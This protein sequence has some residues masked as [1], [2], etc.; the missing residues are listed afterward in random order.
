VTSLQDDITR[1]VK[2]AL[3]AAL[4]AVLL[5]LVIASVNVTNLLL[6]RA[7]QRRGELAMRVALGAGKGRVVRQLLTESLLL[8]IIGGALGIVIAQVGVPA[9]IALSPAALPRVNSIAINGPVFAFAFGISALIG[10]LLALLPAFQ[11]SKEALHGEVQ[12]SARRTAGVRSSTRRSLVVAEVAIALVLLSSAGLLLRSME[13]LFAVAPGFDA[14]HV[15]TMQVQTYGRRYDDDAVCH[16]FFAQALDA[17]RKVP[18][19]SVAAFTSELPLNGDVKDF[20][21]YG[22]EV[23]SREEGGKATVDAFRYAVTPE[24]FKTMDIPLRRGRLFDE[25]DMLGAPARPVLINESLA[26]RVFANQDPIGQRVRFGGLPNRPW[27]VIVG[28]VGDVKQTSLAA[29]QS[30]AFYVTT[31]QWLWADGTRWLVIRAKGDAGALATAL[32]NAIWS[33]DRTQPIVRVSTM[34]DLVAASAAE[35][36]F[37]LILFEAFGLV[38]LALAAI[39][40][41]GVLSGSVTERTRE[42]GVRSALGASR[43][44][45]LGLIIRQGLT[46]TGLGIVIGLTGAAV[47]SEALASLLFGVWRLDPITYFGVVALLAAVSLTACSLPAWRA[48]RVDPAITLRAE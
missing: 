36:R 31:A 37:V 19:V 28:V 20:N 24:Y 29:G 46:L 18:G 32:E 39:G 48:A 30:G 34:E 4:G 17:V 6:A 22:G 25:Y 5:V 23:E 8:T 42:I 47:A 41:Y 11:A 33:V 13:R 12:L 40:I 21:E 3:F 38:A 7:T 14:S 1:G 45:I 44:D 43:T 16:L 26:K 35:R 15:L 10:F 2:P 27:D 9:L